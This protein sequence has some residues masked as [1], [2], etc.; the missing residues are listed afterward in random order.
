MKAKMATKEHRSVIVH[1]AFVST[2]RNMTTQEYLENNIV[3]HEWLTTKLFWDRN[4]AKIYLWTDSFRCLNEPFEWIT[5]FFKWIVQ[6]IQMDDN[7]FF[8]WIAKAIQMD[9]NFFKTDS[10][11]RSNRWHFFFEW[12]ARTGQKDTKS[13]WTAI[14]S[15]TAN[16]KDVKNVLV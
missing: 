2:L 9:D 16:H 10:P 4:S 15:K 11:S 8:K 6:A 7:L 3:Q 14:H 13:V 12:I 5:N 1:D